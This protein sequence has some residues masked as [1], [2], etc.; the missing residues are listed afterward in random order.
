MTEQARVGATL[1]TLRTTRGWRLTEFAEALG[2][3]HS[4]LAN[5]EAGRK[6]L[7]DVLLAR[8]ADQLGVPQMAIKNPE[9][10]VVPTP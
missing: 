6:P 5:I 1:K 8:A 10:P 4:Y 7:T 2:V 9:E 3:S